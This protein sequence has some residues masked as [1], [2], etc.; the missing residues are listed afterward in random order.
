M[1][2]MVL[3]NS[4]KLGIFLVTLMTVLSVVNYYFRDQ[5]LSFLDSFFNSNK[6]DNQQ[7][8][9]DPEHIQQP[10]QESTQQDLNIISFGQELL[11][12]KAEK[13]YLVLFQNSMELRPGG[14][15][16][17]S[18]AEIKVADQ[19]IQEKTVHN[20]AVFDRMV[21]KKPVPPYVV[22]TYLKV[23][24]LGIKDCNWHLDF[25]S[26]ARQFIELYKTTDR[27]KPIDGVIGLTTEILPFI[28]EL[29]GPVTIDQVSGEFTKENA[30]EK[31][32]YEVEVGYKDRGASK[33]ERKSIMEPLL[34][35]IINKV[36][37]MNKLDQLFMISKIQE[38]MDKKVIQFYFLDNRMQNYVEKHNW[39]GQLVKAEDTD[40]LA[41]V[42]ANLGALKTD[43]CMERRLSYI[44]DYTRPQPIANL[45]INYNHTCQE[46]DFMTGDYQSFLRI[47]TQQD[48]RLIT[49]QGF[50]QGLIKPAT[51]PQDR[52]VIDSEADKK[53]FGNMT[54]IEL[55]SGKE[56]EFTYLI[57]SGLVE[58][59]QLYFQKQ[60]GLK[61][62]WL[63][64]V[65]K[66][67][68]GQTTLYNNQV[69]QDVVIQN[70]P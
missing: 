19:Q 48:S 17:G 44:V 51:D 69:T 6:N 22:E 11:G 26:N 12:S 9:N 45:K 23:D 58:N 27:A 18:F 41:I 1:E 2:K 37:A 40:Y 7:V 8:I 28:L 31:L 35:A 61:P 46:K 55:G 38:L 29:T 62:P 53:T 25:S 14:G 36:Q 39:A 60:P 66:T 5:A 4:V 59:Y 10:D 47:Y 64:V 49:T 16:I 52:A 24:R 50:A 42:E 68:T 33:D 34:S 63:E 20:T 67:S 30:L 65:L 32:E 15:F 43:R 21:Q 54:Y 3:K 70:T 57:N 13:Q 56:Y